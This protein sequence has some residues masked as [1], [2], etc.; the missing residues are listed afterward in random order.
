MIHSTTKNFF[1]P[2]Q[3]QQHIELRT[4]RLQIDEPVG[5]AGNG[6]FIIPLPFLSLVQYFY[7][8]ARLQLK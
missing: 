3:K 7:E 1:P 5:R 8:L 2:K 6:E 4:A